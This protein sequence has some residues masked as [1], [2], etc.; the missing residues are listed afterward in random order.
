MINLTDSERL[1]ED[2]SIDGTNGA[3]SQWSNLP[4]QGIPKASLNMSNLFNIVDLY[5]RTLTLDP[6]LTQF[7]FHGVST[8][9]ANMIPQF[10]GYRALPT[11]SGTEY[12]L[13]SIPKTLMKA[14]YENKPITSMRRF[15]WE[16]LTSLS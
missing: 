12:D 8:L 15:Y 1:R 16:L 14:I 5:A 3:A 6:K 13:A 4:G 11:L 10:L 2:R 7:Y 9:N